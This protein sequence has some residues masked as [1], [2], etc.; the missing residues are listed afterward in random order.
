M[1]EMKDQHL[2]VKPRD[3]DYEEKFT[4][5]STTADSCHPSNGI[6]SVGEFIENFDTLHFEKFAKLPFTPSEHET[7]YKEPPPTRPTTTE[8]TEVQW[9]ITSVSLGLKPGTA[10]SGRRTRFWKGNIELNATL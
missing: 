6:P 9:I 2:Y 3:G 8:N 1:I 10:I 5:N 4:W 7:L